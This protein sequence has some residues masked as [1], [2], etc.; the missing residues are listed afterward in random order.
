MRKKRPRRERIAA[1]LDLPPLVVAMV[2]PRNDLVK[3]SA[4][5]SGEGDTART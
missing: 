3:Y 1:T 2:S 5:R 4:N